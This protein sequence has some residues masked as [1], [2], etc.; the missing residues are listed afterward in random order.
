MQVLVA[1]ANADNFCPSRS[2]LLRVTYTSTQSQHSI[3]S[4]YDE[5]TVII[6]AYS[7]SEITLKS[8]VK[9]TYIYNIPAASTPLV[10]NPIDPVGTNTIT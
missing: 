8:S 7:T 4:V 9:E 5:F 10:I 1:A 2:Y 3:R 6:N